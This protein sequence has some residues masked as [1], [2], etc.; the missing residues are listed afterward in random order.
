M[1]VIAEKTSMFWV[2]EGDRR[3]AA[4]L[5]LLLLL[6]TCAAAEEGVLVLQVVDAK[7][8]PFAN[9]RIALAGEGGSPQTS[10][11]NG[12][13]RLRLAPSTKPFAWATLLLRGG[14]QGMDL[15]FVSPFDEPARVRVPPFDNEQDNY[16][17][18]VVVKEGDKE[19][20][21]HASGRLA[22]EATGVAAQRSAPKSE[23]RPIF[24]Q[25]RL[26]TVALRLGP[27]DK[28]ETIATDEL[29]EVGIL[30]ASDRFGLSTADIKAAIAYWGGSPLAWRSMMLTG[31]IEAGGTDPFS[32]VQATSND[33]LFGAG[34][35]SL[36]GCTLQPML[37]KFQEG[38][39]QLFAEIF[40]KEDSAW[41]HK[42]LA[43]SC[44]ASSSM[45][46]ERMLEGP[47][48]MRRSWQEKFRQL[49]S[50]PAFQHVQ[51]PQ[52]AFEVTKALSQALS[53][54][55][56]SDQAVALLAAP[57][58]RRV[59]SAVPTFHEKYLQDVASFSKQFGR[60]PDEQ[61]KLLI[62]KNRTIESWKEQP[63]NSPAALTYFVSLVNLFSDGSGVVSG[64]HYDLEDFGIPVIGRKASAESNSPR[65]ATRSGCAYGMFDEAG[66][67]ELV[68]LI[69]QERTKQGMPPLQVDPRLTQAARKHAELVVQNH[70]LSHQFDGEPTIVVRISNEK[71]PSDQ[72]A[73][74]LAFA[75][76]VADGHETMMQST[77][78]RTNILNRDYNV[79]GVGAARCGGGLWITEDF[80][81]RLPEY[82]ESQADA[83][84]EQA[85]TQYAQAQGMPPPLR[86]PLAQLRDMA[87]EMAKRGT[88]DR[89]GPAQ[90]PGV[91]GTVIWRT[92]NPAELPAHAQTRLSQP[93]PSGYSMGACFAPS[94]SHPGGLYWVVMVN[95]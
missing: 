85:I 24:S 3:W 12:R 80:A 36:R 43:A 50:E 39:G 37:Q 48:V 17:E 21:E 52:V 83:A 29:Q 90:L 59:I 45:L 55:L 88:V 10:D 31:S 73:E 92:D 60:S 61:E 78:H 94:A 11:Q 81:H 70:K 6:V 35:W 32:Y 42:T 62:L 40:G 33:I 75:P 2:E 7:H 69:N 13:L 26:L 67:K 84:L 64:R 14:P 93:M 65:P 77:H 9:V 86:K 20:L 28:N 46:L 66:E 25:P 79:I 1:G 22:I 34:G 91:H 82:S 95:Y 71:L 57:A 49:G 47:G 23:S 44:E 8:H 89:E 19:M 4:V 76:T 15:V 54:G 87:C 68:D 41:L 53:L 18:V 74:N 63:G 30:A 72:E 51:V 56:H 27:W 16:D 5:L 58:I 38:N